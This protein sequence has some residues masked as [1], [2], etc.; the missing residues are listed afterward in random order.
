MRVFMKAAASGVALKH[1]YNYELFC[2]ATNPYYT[3]DMLMHM[4]VHKLHMPKMQILGMSEK[5]SSFSNLFSDYLRF[6]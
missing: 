1:L 2:M 6:L 3:W 5:K 4:G